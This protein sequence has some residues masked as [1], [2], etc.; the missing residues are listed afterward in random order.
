[1]TATTRSAERAAGVGA[2]W[3]PRAEASREQHTDRAPRAD[4]ASVPNTFRHY[5]PLASS[6]PAVLMCSFAQR[7]PG[8]AEQPKERLQHLETILSTQWGGAGGTQK[9]RSFSYKLTLA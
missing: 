4:P 5:R 6:H 2:P 7:E 1:M 9:A 3:W 8:G